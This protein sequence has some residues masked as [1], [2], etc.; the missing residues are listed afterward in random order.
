[1]SI[2]DAEFLSEDG[3]Q[4]GTVD[5]PP[6]ACIAFHKVYNLTNELL[7]QH[8]GTFSAII[9]D[10]TLTGPIDPTLS[11][12][13][14]HASNLDTLGMTLNRK[15]TKVYLPPHLRTPDNIAKCEAQKLQLGTL[16]AEDGTIT[17]GLKIGGI[18]IGDEDYIQLFL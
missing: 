9:D 13:N 2:Y 14:T 7:I 6:L 8:K 12:L 5:G 16:E 17:Y 15:K 3:V 18:P 10:G 4:Q 11:I 1:M